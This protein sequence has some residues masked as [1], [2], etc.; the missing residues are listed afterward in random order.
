MRFMQLD[1]VVRKADRGIDF[2]IE[3]RKVLYPPSFEITPE[4]KVSIVRLIKKGMCDHYAIPV[5]ALQEEL[6]MS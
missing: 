2:M 3:R 4:I 5:E 1:L 6:F